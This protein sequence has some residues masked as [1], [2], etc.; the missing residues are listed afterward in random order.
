MLDHTIKSL[1]GDAGGH[2]HAE[3][4]PGM[5]TSESCADLLWDRSGLEN[6]YRWCL[7]H[8]QLAYRRLMSLNSST[9]YHIPTLMLNLRDPQSRVPTC[10]AAPQPPGVPVLLSPSCLSSLTLTQHLDSSAH[11]GLSLKRH[12]TWPRSGELDGWE[13][14][15]VLGENVLSVFHLR[16][17]AEVLYGR[18]C[19]M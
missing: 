18:I 15:L 8:N 1:L 2:V 7:A 17:Q 3:R 9:F 10:L 11:P 14:E 5:V 12:Q 16:A 13:F 6:Q 4:G 19:Y